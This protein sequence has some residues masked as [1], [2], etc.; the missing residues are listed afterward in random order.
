MSDKTHMHGDGESDS[1]VV[2]AKQPNKSGQPPAEAVEGRPLTKENMDQPNQYRTQKRKS[3][4]SKLAHVREAAKKDKKLKFTALLHHVTVDL[5][6]DSYGALKRGA[7]PG[8]DGVTWQE[9]G[10]DL[11]ERLR[12]LHGRIHRGAY[13]ALPSLRTWIPKAD[14][15]QRPLGIAA[16][17]DKIVQHAVGKVLTQI[18]EEDFLGFSYGFRPGRSQHDALDALWV[19]I[20]RKKVNWILDL[21]I[22]SFFDKVR[23]DW[24]IKFV[25]HR[26]GDKRIVRLIQK[27]LKAGVMEEGRWFETEEGTPQGSV[28]SPV[29]ANLYL[30][31]VLDLWVHQWRHRQA[32][33][34]AIAVRY[35]DDA[36]LGFQHRD[37]AEQFLEQLR[38]RLAKFGLELHPEKTRLIEFGRYATERRKARGEGKPETFDFLGFTHISGTTRKAG[39]FTVRRQTNGKRM[40]AKLKEIRAQLKVRR[41]ESHVKTVKWLQSVVRGYFQYH[42]IP[43]NQARLEAFRQEVLRMWLDQ[44]RRRSQRSRW[45]WERFMER[46]G[47]LLPEIRVLHPYPTVRFDA[48]Y[49]R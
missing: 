36:V 29:L 8:V 48:K 31:F 12:N 44:L 7:A 15:R 32:K 27:W 16:L 11:E 6:R 9:Y 47:H 23:H 18:W 10:E 35:A 2:P 17:E 3:W 46:L 38:E 45:N 14:G 20:T 34:D 37:E 42:A 25:E 39:R 41:H 28:I 22:R 19:G 5:L 26:V 30:H 24:M 13:R 21:D 40:T 1:G 43:D 49:P 4:S 33:G